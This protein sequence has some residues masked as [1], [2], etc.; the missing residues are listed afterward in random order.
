MVAVFF[1]G[2]SKINI[3]KRRFFQMFQKM[4]VD[5]NFKIGQINII[6]CSDDF[7]LKMNNDFLGHNFHTDIITFNYNEKNVVSGDL[8]IGFEQVK[9]NSVLYKVLFD[10]EIA[11]V[12]IHGILHLLGFNDKDRDEKRIMR[13]MEN[14]YLEEFGF[15]L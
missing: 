2:I 4:I 13:M 10:G 11:R 7:I 8:F 1:E 12:L 14:K 5:F 9:R 3:N 15:F 6:F